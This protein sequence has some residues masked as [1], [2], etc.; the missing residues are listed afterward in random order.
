MIK[1]APSPRDLHDE[2]IRLLNEIHRYDGKRCDAA[3]SNNG[4][5][6]RLLFDYVDLLKLVLS[7][8]PALRMPVGGVEKWL[9]RESFKETGLLPDAILFR[10]K[11]A[12]SDGVSS[13]EKSWF[14]HIQDHIDNEVSDKEFYES[15]ESREEFKE[16]Y[17]YKKIFW[18]KKALVNIN[19]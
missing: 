18:A 5:E 10:S 14:Q 16:Q 13:K 6:L 8:D 9:L 4:I 19:I 17:Y 12:F 3:V 11:E 15:K 1:N 2:N 7:I